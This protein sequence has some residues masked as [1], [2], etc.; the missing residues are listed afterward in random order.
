LVPAL[1]Y[2]KPSLSYEQQADLLIGRGLVADRE[3]LIMR[4][5][6]V[7]YYR[8]SGYIYP[9]RESDTLIKAGTTLD[10]V[11]RHYTFDRQLRILMMDAIERV[12][13]AI[14]AELA[15]H[16]VEM[17]DIWG[18]LDPVN[19]PQISVSDHRRWIWK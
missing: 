7:N 8:L 19:L 9:F 14:R 2:T 11:W 18:H 17:H 15:H 10:K 6:T 3:T 16:F 5:K 1:R 12:E 4:L 13:A